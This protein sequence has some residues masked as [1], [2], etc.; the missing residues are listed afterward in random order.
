MSKIDAV[1]LQRDVTSLSTM[2]Q[3]IVV[4]EDLQTA[5][6]SCPKRSFPDL[7]SCSS[8]EDYEEKDVYPNE[9]LESYLVVVGGFLSCFT[10]FGIM[11]TMGAIETYVESHQLAK[12]SVTSVSWIFSIYMFV[13]LFSGLFVGPLYDSFGARW[14]VAIGGLLTFVGNFSMA[15]CTEIW[16]FV[17]AFG[18][19]TGVGTGFMMFP[20]VSIMSSWFNRTKRSFFIGVIQTG[21]SVG[22]IVFPVVLRYLYPKYGFVWAIRI[23]AL[24]NLGVD[25]VA[26]ILMKDRIEEVRV[27]LG[28]K[29]D[30][31]PFVVKVR[32]SLDI[33]AFKD[34]QFMALS[35]ALFMNEFSILILL[36]YIASYAIAYGSS[37][38]QA[39]VMLTIMNV[40]GT[41]GK[42]VPSY[43]SQWVG[44]FNMM[45]LMSSTMSLMCFVVWVPFGKH[46]TALYI[47]IVIFGFAMASTYSLTGACV[48]TIT[49]Q[50]KDFGKRYGSAY[51]FVS[52]GNLV[53]LPISG[54]FIR[55]KSTVDY[56]HMAIFTA[57]TCLAGTLLFLLARYTVVGTKLRTII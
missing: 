21:G 49:K 48:G 24:L 31:R 45:I 42:F 43:F 33:S 47:F 46:S 8:A 28:E 37:E 20:T 32:Q 39:Y 2:A 51:A 25:A 1:A 30:E 41:F 6:E 55:T 56:D 10:L 14:L 16:Q 23:F 22:G 13:S 26:V 19:C 29:K 52:F 4:V 34:K 50:T 54:A 3:E 12:E 40:A 5:A 27:A 11:N 35:S 18:I 57:C 44:T 38:S 17:L 7:E 9:C 15:N 53:S 36:T